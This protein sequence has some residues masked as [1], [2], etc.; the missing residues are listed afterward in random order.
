MS[1]V[2]PEKASLDP[3]LPG[4]LLKFRASAFHVLELGETAAILPIQIAELA[5]AQAQGSIDGLPAG[6]AL[7]LGLAAGS[8]ANPGTSRFQRRHCFRDDPAFV[9]VS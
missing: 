3:C 7:G 5:A 1:F 8:A 4:K 9:A 2:I 6:V